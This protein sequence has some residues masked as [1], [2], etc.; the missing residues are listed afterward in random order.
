MVSLMYLE[1]ESQFE[2]N[3]VIIQGFCFPVMD[4]CL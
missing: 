1:N 4:T 3:D 2:M